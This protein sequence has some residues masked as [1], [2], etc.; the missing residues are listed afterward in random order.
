MHLKAVL[1]VPNPTV[2]KLLLSST[3]LWCLKIL[4]HLHLVHEKNATE[5]L[6]SFAIIQRL[7]G[8]TKAAY[9]PNHFSEEC[10][11]FVCSLAPFHFEHQSLCSIA[12]VRSFLPTRFHWY[13][14]CIQPSNTGHCSERKMNTDSATEI[15]RFPAPKFGPG[16]MENFLHFLRVS[17]L[18][19]AVKREYLQFRIIDKK[20]EAKSFHHE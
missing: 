3:K 12:S 20:L 16:L 9:I 10:L 6:N 11:V 14:H 8:L 5:Q 19:A 18:G 17:I 13:P 2:H 1:L 4:F 7:G 15:I